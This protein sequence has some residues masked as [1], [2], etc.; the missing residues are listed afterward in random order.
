MNELTAEQFQRMLIEKSAKR[1][2]LESER[3]SKK[4]LKRGDS[5]RK[6][7]RMRDEMMLNREINR[8][9]GCW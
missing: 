6:I 5:L 2:A 4:D 8:I 3:V 9:M 1:K 7:E